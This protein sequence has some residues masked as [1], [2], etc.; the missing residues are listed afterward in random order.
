MTLLCQG[1]ARR[2]FPL[3]SDADFEGLEESGYVY[4]VRDKLR[5]EVLVPLR[6]AL[7]LPEVF[8]SAKK[9]ESLPYNRV[10]SVAMKNYKQLFPSMIRRGLVSI[11]RM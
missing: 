4:K 5:K 3:D 11:L 7:E 6:R 2:I 8:M 10:P 1:I 9:W